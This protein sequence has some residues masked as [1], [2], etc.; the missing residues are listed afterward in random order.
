MGYLDP[1]LRVIWVGVDGRSWH[2]AGP[3]SRRSPVILDYPEGLIAQ[4]S[5]ATTP[6][7]TGVGV[8][9]EKRSFGELSGSLN[10]TAFATEIQL[11]GENYREWAKSFDTE[12]SGT[13]K[14]GFPGDLWQISA[15][16][17]VDGVPKPSP[18]TPGL[19]RLP[20]K[21]Q[22]NSFDG[23]W[24]GRTRKYAGAV[25]TVVNSGTLPMFPLVFWVGSDQSVTLPHG[26]TIDLPPV[27]QEHCLST[28]PGTGF[29]VTAGGEEATD[30]WR[31]FRGRACNGLVQSRQTREF[32]STAGVRIEWTPRIED[33]WR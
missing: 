29:V 14:V 1:L 9:P 32:I 22:L 12:L 31:L 21:M 16:G 7:S 8:R 26:V 2:L 17:K 20:L 13:L 19:K 27:A 4:P 33:P 6:S 5:T 18:W 10:V 11:L 24:A 15:V 25:A 28:D 3:S 30:V 23:V